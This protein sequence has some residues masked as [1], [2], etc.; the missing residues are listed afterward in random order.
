MVAE[1]AAGVAPLAA[2]TRLGGRFAVRIR[3]IRG[4]MKRATN[5]RGARM[6][7]DPPKRPDD[8]TRDRLAR[9]LMEQHR[10]I[11]ERDT[12]SAL[13]RLP[14]VLITMMLLGLLLYWLAS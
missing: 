2:P 8:E 3:R 13:R 10:A 5:S 14:L 12:R 11:D 6:T 7:P 1:D 4:R 9:E